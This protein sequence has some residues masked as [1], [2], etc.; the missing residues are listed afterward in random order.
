MDF[1]EK[2]S[3]DVYG[4]EHLA[5][6]YGTEKDKVNCPF[7][8]KIGACRHGRKCTRN[9]NRPT[10]S[11]TILIPHMYQS[12]LTMPLIDT[13]GNPIKFD[14]TFLNNHSEDF[15]IDT[16]EEFV[17][18]GTLEELV[19][20][21]NV[22][23]HLQ[24]NVYVKYAKEQ[25]AKAALTAL[26][27]RFYGGR[28]LVPEFS[29]VTDFK[30][31]RCK[32]FEQTICRR[33][34]M[35]NFMHLKKVPSYLPFYEGGNR[36]RD[37]RS[38]RGY[39][40]SPDRYRRR[41]RSRS[42]KRDYERKYNRSRSPD[43]YRRRNYDH[44]SKYDSR[45]HYKD[46]RSSYSKYGDSQKPKYTSEQNPR[47]ESF[48]NYSKYGDSQKPKY[49]S[50]QNENQQKPKYS[51][52]RFSNYSKYDGG[53][54]DSF[55]QSK[56]GNDQQD[57][58][59]KYK[60]KYYSNE[61]KSKYGDSTKQNEDDPMKY[62]PKYSNNDYNSKYGDS[63]QQDRDDSIKYKPKYSNDETTDPNDRLA[64]YKKYY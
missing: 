63:N 47:S 40:R 34:G 4:A 48:S 44:R 56:Y 28:T 12:P 27:G 18:Y 25:D 36:S 7:Y 33:G 54:N 23:E 13:S 61:Y 29:P 22:C 46:S 35:C 19:V 49:S 30:E 20:C 10:I 1:E 39:S 38:G 51:S 11:Q 41:N 6:I 64:K 16:W 32:E 53:N 57:D 21:D 37:R 5:D 60:P 3:S 43:P 58:S 9:H 14:E 42:P 8:W 24:G 31:A 45:D 52:D 59:M 2:K 17:K 62:K 50:E 15:F 55:G 26:A